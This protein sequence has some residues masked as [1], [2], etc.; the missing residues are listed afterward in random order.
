MK[1]KVE[2]PVLNNAH[3]TY[4]Y[5]PDDSTSFIQAGKDP[6]VLGLSILHLSCSILNCFLLLCECLFNV[7]CSICCW[8]MMEV[9]CN[10]CSDEKLS[11]PMYKNNNHINRA[12]TFGFLWR[13]SLPNEP[14]F[15]T[16][17][18]RSCMLPSLNNVSI[19]L[20]AGQRGRRAESFDTNGER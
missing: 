10:I 13:H 7:R 9:F 12:Y 4:F 2:V 16:F 19:M 8:S 14:S 11:C 5:Y 1:G 6:V 15:S 18:P 17:S 20:A 3:V